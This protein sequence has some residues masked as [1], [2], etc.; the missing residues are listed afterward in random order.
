MLH[1][2]ITKSLFDFETKMQRRGGAGSQKNLTHFL[3]WH[4]RCT[5]TC[6]HAVGAGEQLWRRY[7]LTH[8]VPR[9]CLPGYLPR[10]GGEAQR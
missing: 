5:T 2:Y 9:R 8:N 7:N 1:H 10:G 3:D 6:R 4:A